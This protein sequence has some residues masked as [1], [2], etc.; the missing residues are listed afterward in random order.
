VALVQTEPDQ[1]TYKLSVAGVL[2]GL[3][4]P[5]ADVVTPIAGLGRVEFVWL[6]I[7]SIGDNIP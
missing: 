3:F 2:G 7:H 6:T 5:R 4:V 1:V